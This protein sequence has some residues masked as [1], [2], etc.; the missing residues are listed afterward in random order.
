[1]HEQVAISLRL[2]SIFEPVT[3][4]MQRQ[5]KLDKPQDNSTGTTTQHV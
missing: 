3:M 1:M 5:R 4:D 2:F